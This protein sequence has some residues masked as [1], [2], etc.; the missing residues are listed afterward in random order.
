[1]GRWV[2]VVLA[3]M[4]TLAGCSSAPAADPAPSGLPTS[5]G[6]LPTDEVVWAVGSTV[7]VGERSF[8]TDRPVRAMVA[9][10]GRV[11]Y[12]EGHR[13]ELMV[14]DGVRSRSTGFETDRLVASADGRHLAFLDS[15]DGSPWS[16]L[17]LDLMAGEV[18]VDDDSGM[19]EV[20]EDLADLY[21]DAQPEPL[22][23]EGDE[24]YVRAAA[25]DEI[26]S[27]DAST[28]ERTDH[29]D[30]AFVAPFDPGGGRRLPALIRNGRLVVPQD[31]YRSTQWGHASP[32]ATVTLQP[33]G[34]R[35]GL[36]AVD[37]GRRLPVDLRGRTFVLGGWINDTT[38]YGVSFDRSARGPVRLV[39]CRLS[40]AEQRC[41]VLREVEKPRGQLVLFPTG[42]PATDY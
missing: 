22:G 14:S 17:V 16:T 7:H 13:D 9:A 2:P 34:D 41:R 38:A 10:R 26:R 29:G 15:S 1:M 5:M 32:E 28:G 31:P 20:G 3:A 4:A 37:S 11:Y 18:V 39:S 30:R 24:L 33:V 19:G 8:S 36:F 25:G 6:P 27:W 21:E 23:F 40:L 12:L 35:T 42:S